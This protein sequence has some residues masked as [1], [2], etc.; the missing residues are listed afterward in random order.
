MVKRIDKLKNN[1][2]NRPAHYTFHKSGIEA[3][4]V[5]GRMGF[6]L[7]NAFKYCFRMDNKGKPLEDLKKARWYINRFLFELGELRARKP[8]SDFNYDKEWSNDLTD[9]TDDS[10]EYKNI[11]K[12]VG[13]EPGNIEKAIFYV[14]FAE[15]EQDDSECIWFLGLAL[16]YINKEIRKRTR[17][18]NKT[19]KEK[20]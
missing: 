20:T 15:K 4:E 14:W 13:N 9:Y 8:L 19:K 16:H 11:L 5:C 12:I 1:P 10:G 3:I 2:V 18:V 6:C 17:L 7:G